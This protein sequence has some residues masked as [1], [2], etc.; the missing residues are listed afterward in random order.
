MLKEFKEFVMRGNML[1]MAV[2]IVMGVAFGLIV[3]SLVHDVIMPPIGPARPHR[4][5]QHVFSHQ[6]G[7][8][9]RA[10]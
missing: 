8:S 7:E 1:D 6:G 2:G 4:L 10:R 5:C 9:G 3:N